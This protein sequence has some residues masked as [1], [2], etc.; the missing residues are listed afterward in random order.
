MTKKPPFAGAL[1]PLFMEMIGDESTKRDLEKYDFDPELYRLSCVK[2]ELDAI[3]QYSKHLSDYLAKS[4]KKHNRAQKQFT[5]KD[6]YDPVI[7]IKGFY[8]P[9]IFGDLA[10]RMLKKCQENSVPPPHELC[11]F[12]ET[13]FNIEGRGKSNKGKPYEREL[14]VYYLVKYP[15]KKKRQLAEELRISRSNLYRWLREP[16]FKAQIEALKKNLEPA[17]K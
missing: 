2:G 15:E 1:W 6:F 14:A 7:S 10:C 17:S 11:K 16:D 3:R 8:A 12:F 9:H 4:R 5:K 13:I